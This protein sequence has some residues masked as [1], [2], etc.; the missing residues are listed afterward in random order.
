LL[1]A[2][3]QARI[4]CQQV[5]VQVALVVVA[6]ALAIMAHHYGQVIQVLTKG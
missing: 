5:A 4:I 6:V 3:V 1:E 2:V